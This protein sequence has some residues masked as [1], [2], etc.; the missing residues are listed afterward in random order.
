MGMKSE[1]RSALPFDPDM[2]VA[3]SVIGSFIDVSAE[4]VRKLAEEGVLPREGKG[5]F[6]LR[7]CIK[8]HAAWSRDEARRGSRTASQSRVSDARAREIEIRVAKE[9]HRLIE[10]EDALGALDEIIGT[11]RSEASG[12]PARVTRDVALRRK[13]ESEIDDIFRRASARFERAA[14]DLRQ[15]GEALPHAEEDISG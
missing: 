9:E 3:A 11:L 13:V 10:T 2:L 15:G 14:V 1:G 12:L 4:R 8:A 7:A 6:P 5:R